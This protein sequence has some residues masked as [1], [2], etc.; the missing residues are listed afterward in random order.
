VNDRLIV[1][2][3]RTSPSAQTQIRALLT[4]AGF[5]ELPVAGA[6]S[7]DAPA[8]TGSGPASFA[9]PI[10]SGIPGGGLV[11]AA[12]GIVQ[13]AGSQLGTVSSVRVGGLLAEV[14]SVTADS[15]ELR[16]PAGLAAGTY[17]LVIDSSAGQVT[18]TGAI[19]IRAGTATNVSQGGWTRAS[20][21]ATGAVTSV[22]MYMRD[23]IG[24]GKVQFKVNGR[25]I[26]WVRA[27]DA[28]DPKLR[29]LSN[30][31]QYLVRNVRLEPGKN[32]LEIFVDGT[33][34]WRAAYTGR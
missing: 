24:I 33:R 8:Q 12:G 10:L 11:A 27:V 25:E 14:L 5:L 2:T 26:A 22:R 30:G 32:A 7:L 34:I 13:I 4:P 1:S 21:D 29:T 16:L 17:D 31:L 9:G 15:L 28:T 20:V 18:I 6:S 19:V 23:P 3:S